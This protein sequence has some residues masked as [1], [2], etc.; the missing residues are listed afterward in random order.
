VWLRLDN[1]EHCLAERTRR[2]V[3]IAGPPL[4]SEAAADSSL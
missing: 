4:E 2:E 1:T 3:A